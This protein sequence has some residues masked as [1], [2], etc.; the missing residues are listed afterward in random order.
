MM[1][2]FKLSEFDSPD[3]TGSGKN[4]NEGFLARLDLAR[5]IAGIT[6]IVTSGYRTNKHNELVGGVDSSAHT[7]GYAADLACRDSVSRWIIIKAL[8]EA[9]FNR[10]GIADTFIHVDSDPD[11]T[12]NVI[13]TY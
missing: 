5:E 9:G 3:E 6:F 11:K 4:M 1:K 10:I 12:G 13:W 8:F 2:Y 7:K